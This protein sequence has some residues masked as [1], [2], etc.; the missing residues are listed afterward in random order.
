MFEKFDSILVEI[1]DID[2]S[3][4]I[5]YDFFQDDNSDSFDTFISDNK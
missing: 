1:D 4:L 3:A 2:P 5:F